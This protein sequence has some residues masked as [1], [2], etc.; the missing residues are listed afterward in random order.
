MQNEAATRQEFE[1]LRNRVRTA[2]KPEIEGAP[3]WLN[4]IEDMREFFNSTAPLWDRVFGSEQI[5][6]LY[7][8]VAKQIAATNEIVHILVLGCG[9]GLELPGIFAKVP[10]AQVTGIDL[11]PNMLVEL[12]RKFANHSAQLTLIEGSYLHVPLG[13]QRF[14]YV[15]A[16]LTV[17]H[18]PPENKVALYRRIQGAL[19]PTGR[20]I[21]GDQSTDLVHEQEILFWYDAYIAKLPGGSQTAWNYDVTLSPETQKRLLREAGFNKIRLTWQNS[22]LDLVVFTAESQED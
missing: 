18:V 8:S 4:S 17:H 16:T 19:K 21:E 20:Y 7:Q 9:T 2:P 14:D 10:N 13:E 12:S 15:V 3:D 22:E 1:K 6:P 5:A 11:A